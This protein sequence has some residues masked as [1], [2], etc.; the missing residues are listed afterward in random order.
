MPN[1]FCT[2]ASAS[3]TRIRLR[4]LILGLATSFFINSSSS[5]LSAS[6]LSSSSTR[7]RSTL[8][9]EH[10]GVDGEAEET[11]VDPPTRTSER[12][13]LSGTG[14]PSVAQFRQDLNLG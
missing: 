9:E 1:F 10:R 2:S 4:D 3:L 12:P 7:I 8:S 14:D 11:R 6:S 13:A 5:F